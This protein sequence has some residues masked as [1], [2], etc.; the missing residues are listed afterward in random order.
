MQRLSANQPEPRIFDI[1]RFPVRVTAKGK[2]SAIRGNQ[3]LPMGTS[4]VQPIEQLALF[5]R[6]QVYFLNIKE[7]DGLA[8]VDGLVQHSETRLQSHDSFD[9]R[10]FGEQQRR[11]AFGTFQEK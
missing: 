10:Q 9:R 7:K 3:A 5:L 2:K 1:L 8:G 4:M 6:L 11:R